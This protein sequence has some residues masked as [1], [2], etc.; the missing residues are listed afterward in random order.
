MNQMMFPMLEAFLDWYEYMVSPQ[1]S[2]TVNRV[3]WTTPYGLYNPF[4]EGTQERFRQYR[5]DG[6]L[7]GLRPKVSYRDAR[8]TAPKAVKP[9]TAT[10]NPS[11]TST[12]G[13]RKRIR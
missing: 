10:V 7:D 13:K 9:A 1:K 12:A 3:H 6:S 11:E 8:E 2:S 4:M 5:I